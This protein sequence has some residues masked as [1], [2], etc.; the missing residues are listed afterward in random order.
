MTKLNT[1]VTNEY[2]TMKLG[3]IIEAANKVEANMKEF[4]MHTPVY[5]NL[6]AELIKME[7]ILEVFSAA[8]EENE[9]LLRLGKGARYNIDQHATCASII[10]TMLGQTWAVIVEQ[11][12]PKH[13]LVKGADVVT[14]S[15]KT[16]SAVT[17]DKSRAMLDKTVDVV[18]D[19]LFNMSTWI[20]DKTKR[21]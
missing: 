12:R 13:S 6:K 16:A 21:K 20:A 19:G 3:Q 11:Y 5:K 10:E 2:S 8:K 17:V 15:V 1:L 14:N 7:E 18:F 4:S 9:D